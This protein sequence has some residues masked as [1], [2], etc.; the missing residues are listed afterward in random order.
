MTVR[1]TRLRSLFARSRLDGLVVSDLTNVRYLCGYTGSN[2]MMLVTMKQSWFFTDF[3][4]REMMAKQVQ[5]CRKQVRK[6]DLYAEF[7]VER[8]VGLERVGVERDHLTLARFRLLK[9]QLKRIR[10][11]PTED[12]V[13]KLRR[14]KNPDETRLVE[15]AQ[16]GIERIFDKVLELVR[17]GVRERDLAAEIVY[18]SLKDGEPAF[19]PIVA[20]GPNSASPHY[21]P[22]TRKLKNG[23]AV[24]FDLGLRFRGYCSDMTRTVFLGKPKGELAKVYGIVLEAQQQALAAIRPGVRCR[25]V[26]RAARSHITDAGFGQFFGH[27]LGHG[28]GLAVHELPVLHAKSKQRLGVGDVVTVEPG[29]YLPGTGGVRIEDMVVVTSGGCRNL[30]RS[31]KQLTRL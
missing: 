18:Q 14:T 15:K 27:G 26:D 2:G 3:R 19:A 16:A 30:T 17:P 23:D 11:V 7:P 20:S 12:L 31:P 22:G 29:I 24:T 9:R 21:D 28:V 13:L 1:T 25:D 10:L 5:G 6:R 8:T 4:Y